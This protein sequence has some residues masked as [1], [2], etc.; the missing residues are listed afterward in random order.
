MVMSSTIYVKK[1]FVLI[2]QVV[3]PSFG[4]QVQVPESSCRITCFFTAPMCL[5][6]IS[7]SLFGLKTW[8][9]PFEFLMN[10]SGLYTQKTTFDYQWRTVLP[11]VSKIVNCHC[12]RLYILCGPI[13]AWAI[14]CRI[15]Q[16][17]AHGR[18]CSY[19]LM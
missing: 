9:L 5:T 17:F 6:L 14:C 4:S 1:S 18:F 10:S 2:L 11:I 19:C 8:K 3:N 13:Q 12:K 7:Q 15:L 16:N